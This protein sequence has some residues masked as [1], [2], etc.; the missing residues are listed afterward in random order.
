MTNYKGGGF[1]TS[2]ETDLLTAI[3]N[4]NLPEVKKLV[5]MVNVNNKDKKIWSNKNP[6]LFYAI[7]YIVT[8]RNDKIL[9]IIKAI[10]EEG[11]GDIN[12]EFVTKGS[13]YRPITQT[14]LM[15]LLQNK[16]YYT[17]DI[18]LTDEMDMI[19]ERYIE[20]AKY[21][22][23]NDADLTKSNNDRGADL[24]F[25]PLMY[26]CTDTYEHREL[27]KLI[28]EKDN[29]NINRRNINGHTPLM[30]ACMNMN[31]TG[32]EQYIQYKLEAI[33]ALIE[34]GA[35][36]NKGNI[37][38]FVGEYRDQEFTN[39]L[40]ILVR[41]VERNCHIYRDIIKLLINSGAKIDIEV[42]PY[43]YRLRNDINK[44]DPDILRNVTPTPTARSLTTPNSQGVSKPPTVNGRA[45]T[46]SRTAAST[47]NG[48]TSTV[49]R[50]P[51]PPLP[52][53]RTRPPPPPPR[54]QGGR[55]TKK[56]RKKFE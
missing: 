32:G 34:N 44:C 18:G 23:N 19:M 8:V 53:P 49:N 6:P 30:I 51:P 27:I 55:F 41:A 28:L 20:I 39:P 5:K 52:P 3:R 33:K 50:R 7:S 40:I 9:D 31:V 38:T 10:V 35:D 17:E 36:V 1:F 46:V 25:T 13:T 12:L 48:R 22:I 37:D 16:Y 29:T 21:L 42:Y 24:D 26:A 15:Y 45:S 4:N 14:P 11:G 56:N 54:K 43:V 47:L 2:N